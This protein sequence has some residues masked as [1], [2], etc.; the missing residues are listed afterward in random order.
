MGNSE[1]HR[2]EIIV[3]NCSSLATSDE[4]LRRI[5]EA[6]FEKRNYSAAKTICTVFNGGCPKLQECLGSAMQYE[7]WTPGVHRF[8]VWG[9]FTP[10]E[11]DALAVH[12]KN[13]KRRE[14][15]D[16]RKESAVIS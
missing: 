10:E 3:G 11:R 14:R 5:D 15:Y 12:A 9:G 7:S 8:G 16:R 2:S 6:F 13:V 4:A 1:K